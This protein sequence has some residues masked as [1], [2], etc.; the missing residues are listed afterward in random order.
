MFSLY[1]FHLIIA[2][3]L[4]CF[5]EDSFLEVVIVLNDLI[6]SSAKF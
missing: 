4:F 5:L 3:M 1:V 2:L 6:K